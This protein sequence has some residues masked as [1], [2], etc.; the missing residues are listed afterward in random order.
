MGHAAGPRH[1]RPARSRRLDRL[2]GRLGGGEGDAAVARV[3][4]RVVLALHSRRC[5]DLDTTAGAATFMQPRVRR[6]CCF[7]GD[8]TCSP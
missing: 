8:T 4:G 6:S 7:F 5:G 2:F 1:A 3:G